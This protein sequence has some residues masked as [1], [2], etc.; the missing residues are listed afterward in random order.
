[1]NR[2]KYVRSDLIIN[3]NFILMY[4]LLKQNLVTFVYTSPIEDQF[5]PKHIVN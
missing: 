1:M 3:S 2:Y 5:W 4:L